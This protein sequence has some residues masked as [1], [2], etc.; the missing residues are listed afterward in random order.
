M[1]MGGEAIGYDYKQ[2][3]VIYKFSFCPR[4]NNLDTKSV[5]KYKL[6]GSN[7]GI[8]WEEIGTYT[9][10]DPTD[11][12]TI[13]QDVECSK[14]YSKY[15]IKYISTFNEE[16]STT[17][18]GVYELKFFVR[19]NEKINTDKSNFNKY[20]ENLANL[21]SN[22]L[23]YYNSL[24]ELMK[25]DNNTLD[26]LLNCEENLKY[27]IEKPQEFK[28][29]IIL[30]D[31][32]VKKLIDYNIDALRNSEEWLKAIEKTKYS[33]IINIKEYVDTSNYE[34]GSIL[35]TS[36]YT[37]HG[38]KDAFDGD[39]KTYWYSNGFTNGK[40]GQ[41]IGYDF[42]KDVVIYKFSFMPRNNQI[43][44]KSVS[45][46]KLEGSNDGENWEDIETYINDDSADASTITN[47]VVCS[48]TYSKYRI[49]YITT[50]N[51]ENTTTYAGVYEAIFYCGIL[52]N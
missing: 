20:N 31:K 13:T 45:K 50:F 3:K 49:E 8:E 6:E 25:S 41:A 1:E 16:A 9:N 14:A 11:A 28:D 34:Q 22:S 4:N 24:D 29:A 26:I 5:S 33:V 40:G 39:K 19:D 51:E 17:Y 46:Y 15:R 23:I 21:Y 18:A 52:N 2:K 12:I 42:K 44:T 36:T 27:I 32:A 35:V 48:K 30:N 7:D 47:D 43:D 37:G 38:K 10:D